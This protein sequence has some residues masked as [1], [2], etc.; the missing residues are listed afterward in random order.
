VKQ[1][2]PALR[3]SLREWVVFMRPI[4]IVEALLGVALL[5]IIDA[6]IPASWEWFHLDLY[7]LWIV[8]LAIAA[9]YGAPA[10]YV[11]GIAAA[12]SFEYFAIVHA[13]PLQPV[14]LSDQ[15]QPILL[16]S[17]GVMVSEI[18]RAHKH[19]IARLTR[20]T[21][22]RERL[23]EETTTSLTTEAQARA[24]L[25]HRIA[26]QPTS[27]AM[28][29]GFAARLT[30]PGARDLAPEVVEVIQR[31][32]EAE[33][34]ALYL[35][36]DPDTQ[37]TLRLRA[38]KPEAVV[39]RPPLLDP[40]SPLVRQILRERRVLTVRDALQ[41]VE[42]AEMTHQDFVMAGPLVSP[43][44]TALGIVVVERMPFPKFTPSAVRLF[45]LALDWTARALAAPGTLTAA[46]AADPHA[47]AVVPAWRAPS[48]DMPGAGAPGEP[49]APRASALGEPAPVERADQRQ[50]GPV[51]QG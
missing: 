22:E 51:W 7:A 47:G 34:C 33:A 44:A 5:S 6:L 17:A 4:E 39:T 12:A 16:L 28:I 11:A 15:I 29:V 2:S 3:R 9:R 48:A 1:E 18:V 49:R 38:G 13:D 46:R 26:S 41:R 21:A 24:E 20:E 30:A 43:Q 40:N 31:L 27:M 19:R 23:L 37:A 10:G 45:E 8:V 14:A 32:L 42:L 35:F 25:E 36:D 50:P